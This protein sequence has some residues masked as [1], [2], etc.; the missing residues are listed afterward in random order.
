V[1]V[2]LVAQHA[3][4][5]YLYSAESHDRL[6]PHRLKVTV[7][8]RDVTASVRARLGRALP[9]PY[10]LDFNLFTASAATILLPAL[11]SDAWAETHAPGPEGLVGGYAVR[12][13]R[14]GV[15][16][17]LPAEWSRE[18]AVAT[19]RAS[20]AWDGIGDIE[21]DGTISFTDST[22]SAL[23]ALVGRTMDRLRPEAAASL[24]VELAASLN[25][26]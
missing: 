25:A 26:P 13:S 20:L 11:V 17:D 21:G 14:R 7:G 9:I 1:A 23:R 4:E 16:L 12:A 19:N 2:K 10:E 5:Y 18:E 24:A 8:G 22:A 6:P 3:F 15:E